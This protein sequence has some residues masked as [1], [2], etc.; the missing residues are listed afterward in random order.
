VD[1]RVTLRVTHDRARWFEPSVS[2]TPANDTTVI[3]EL[4]RERAAQ[5]KVQS[6]TLRFV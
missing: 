3:T 2:F 4:A 6:A 1:P 5:I